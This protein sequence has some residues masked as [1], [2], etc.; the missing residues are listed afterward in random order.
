V[1]R[2]VG[3]LSKV[4]LEPNFV[5]DHKFTTLTMS[6]QWG[7]QPPPAFQYPIQTGI[8]FQQYT[9]PYAGPGDGLPR[10]HATAATPTTRRTSAPTNRI[11]SSVPAASSYGVPAPSYGSDAVPAIWHDSALFLN[12]PQISPAR[13]GFSRPHLVFPVSPR[14]SQVPVEGRIS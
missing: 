6:Q 1:S 9:I 11:P 12:F 4:R 5:T 2:N 7:G 13:I 14:G 10:S 3:G 8:P